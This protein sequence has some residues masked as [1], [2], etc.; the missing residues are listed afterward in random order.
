M[1]YSGDAMLNYFRRIGTPKVILWC[2]LL[3]YL[4]TV[5]FN[6]DPN[7]ELWVNALGISLVVGTAL[8]LSVT[9]SGP[10]QPDRWQSFR[11]FLIP[12]CVSSFATLT[13]DRGYVLVFPTDRDVL[14]WSIGVCVVF[15][16]LLLVLKRG[17]NALA[18]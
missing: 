13:K 17:G 18:N 1:Q 10:A 12:F 14:F 3:W 8:S 15:V 2:Y 6:F 16:L 5:W 4:A 7:L 11:L 9:R